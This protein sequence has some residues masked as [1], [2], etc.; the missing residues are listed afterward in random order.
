MKRGVVLS[1]T[2]FGSSL[3]PWPEGMTG[4]DGNP[5]PPNKFQRWLNKTWADMTRKVRRMKPEFLVFN[6]D[7]LSGTRGRYMVGNRRTHDADLQVEAARRMLGPIFKRVGQL[8]VIRGTTFHDGT[9]GA[10]INGLAAEFGAMPDPMSHEPTWRELFLDLD[11]AVVHFMHTISTT[12]V[13]WY[14]ATA[15]LRDALMLHDEITRLFGRDGPNVKGIVRSHRH[16]AIYIQTDGNP[17]YHA[18]ITPG[19]ELK[20]DYPVQKGVVVFP[21]IGYV[22]ITGAEGE[23]AFH[24]AKYAL[25]KWAAEAVKVV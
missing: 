9:C 12:R 5:L 13:S 21:T 17:W 10:L 22:T 1:D 11:G 24:L 18:C 14:A 8:F 16:R 15:P 2:Q 20:T 19:W 7:M 6:G 4:R 3:A 23:L 25:P